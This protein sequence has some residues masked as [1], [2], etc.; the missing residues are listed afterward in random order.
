M[1]YYRDKQMHNTMSIRDIQTLFRIEELEAINM[2]QYLNSE[3]KML[4]KTNKK[5]H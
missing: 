1:I 4:K 3:K 2:H 5:L